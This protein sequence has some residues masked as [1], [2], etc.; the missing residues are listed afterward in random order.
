MQARKRETKKVD[1]NEGSLKKDSRGLVMS[2]VQ[3]WK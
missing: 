1:E 3:L 2:I